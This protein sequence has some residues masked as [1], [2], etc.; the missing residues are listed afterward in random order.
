M[1]K[2]HVLHQNNPYVGDQGKSVLSHQKMLQI[3]E[4]KP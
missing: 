4:K 2:E 3:Q 1:I